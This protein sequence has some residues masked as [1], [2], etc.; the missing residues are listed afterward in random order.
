[1][2][3]PPRSETYSLPA[4]TDE[5]FKANATGLQLALDLMHSTPRSQT[6]ELQLP[7]HLPTDGI[8]ETATLEILAPIVSGGASHLGATDSFAHMNPP[9]LWVSW[10]TTL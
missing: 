4:I 2:R 1:M 9:T 10:A 8:G 3:F 7:E 6:P 5:A